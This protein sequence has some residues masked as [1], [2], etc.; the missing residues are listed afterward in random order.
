VGWNGGIA[1]ELV[2]L[3]V[4]NELRVD[5]Q[6]G[7]NTHDILLSGSSTYGIYPCIQRGRWP[8]SEEPRMRMRRLP[9][10]IRLVVNARARVTARESDKDIKMRVNVTSEPC[11]G[12][13]SSGP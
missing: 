12:L 7:N 10:V 9:M 8:S 5:D 11:A 13:G 6:A 2:L 4:M 3:E 1:S